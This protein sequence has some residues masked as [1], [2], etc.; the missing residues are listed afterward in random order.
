MIDA[1]RSIKACAAYYGDNADAME[2]YLKEGEK[3][4]LKLGNRG[5]I[6]FDENGNLCPEIRKAYSDNGFYIFE[7]VINPDEL[8][9]IKEDLVFK[10]DC[11]IGR[12]PGIRHGPVCT[13]SGALW[14]IY[15]SDMY[16]GL[17]TDVADW[18]TRIGGYLATAN[19]SRHI[20]LQAT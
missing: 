18:E 1:S 7:N 10:K 20:V 3:K 8:E 4:A 15:L 14:L 6:K 19:Y 11:Y 16:T 5:Q 17:Y 12:P 13:Q 9:D 2:S